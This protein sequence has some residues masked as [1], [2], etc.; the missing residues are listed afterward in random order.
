MA[1]F[2]T[3]LQRVLQNEGGY[4][5]DPS[6]PGGETYKGVA[7]KMNSTWKGWI[8]IDIAKKQPGFPGNMERNTVLQEM[9]HDF[10]KINYWDRVGAN[11]IENESVAFAIFDFA[12]NAG[13]GPSASLAQKVVGAKTDGVIGPVTVEALNKFDPEHFIAA[14]TVLKIARYITI[15]KNRPESKK[16]FFGWVSRALNC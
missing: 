3:A 10:Y 6:D 15:V 16:Y 2:E 9:I 5:V 8:E 7:R 13:V 14:F 12:V 11:T 4:V 1:N